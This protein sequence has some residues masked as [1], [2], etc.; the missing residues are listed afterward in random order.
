MSRSSRQKEKYGNN[1]EKYQDKYNEGTA[2]RTRPFSFDDIMLKRVNKRQSEDVK[3]VPEGSRNRSG[4]DIVEGVSNHVKSDRHRHRDSVPADVKK[5][6]EDL[7]KVSSRK[8]EDSSSRREGKLVKGNEKVSRDL[9]SKLKATPDR[10]YSGDKAKGGKAD[11]RAHRKRKNEEWSSDNFDNEHEKR[12]SRD[13]VARER[14]ADRSSGKYDKESK[15]KNQNDDERSRDRNSGKKHDLETAERKGKKES[16]QLP[17]EDSRSKR[18]RSRSREHDKDRARKSISLSPRQHKR[19]SY[20]VHEHGELPS[21]SSKGRSG[22]IH[23]DVERKKISFNGSSSDYRRN[24]D[25]ARRLGGY[26]PRKRRT[27]AA[28][29]TPSPTN[30]SPEKRSATWDLPPIRTESKS[31]GSVPYNF[32]S[33]NQTV[34]STKQDLS[35]MISVTSSTPKP[36]VGV[37]SGASPLKINASVD[38]VQLTQA[39]RPMRRV[40]VENLPASATEEAV[41]ECLNS[42]LLSSGVIHVQATQPCI[43]CIINKEKGQALVEFLTPEDASAALSFDGRS[44]FGSNIKIRRPKDYVEVTCGNSYLEKKVGGLLFAAEFNS[45]N[46]AVCELVRSRRLSGYEKKT[47]AVLALLGLGRVDVQQIIIH[48]SCFRMVMKLTAK[49]R[50]FSGVVANFAVFADFKTG[51]PEKS[52]AATISVSDIVKDS[53]HK[54]FI[55][56]ISKVISSQMLMEIASA[57]GPLKAYHYEFNADL[58]EPY[59]FIEFVD[60]AVTSKA[61]AGLN[62]IRLGGKVLTVVQAIHDGLPVENIG[63]PPFYE[64]PEHA[65]PLL[66]NPTQVLKL[67]NVLDLHSLSSLSEPELEEILEDIRLECARFGTVISVNVVKC[68]TCSTDLE[69]YEVVDTNVSAIGD[70]NLESDDKEER[71]EI[72]SECLDGDSGKVCRSEPSSNADEPEVVHKAAE[73]SSS[74]DGRSEPLSSARQDDEADEAVESSSNCNDKLVDN[75]VKEETCEAAPLD[76]PSIEENLNAIGRDLSLPMKAEVDQLE[77][78]D[79]KVADIL[80]M[81]D[82]P[83][84][85]IPSF[86][87]QLKLEEEIGK[88]S[89]S[90][91]IAKIESD[92]LENCGNKGQSINLEDIF[93]PGCVLVKFK[94]AE[95]SSNAAHCFH[96]RLF[97]NRVVTVEYVAHEHYKARF[98]K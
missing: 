27:E 61:C 97:D 85:D 75:L 56:G 82:L 91:N 52:V 39:T 19:T 25:S 57:F 94:R 8:K 89:D 50:R 44:F 78:D 88:F 22:R 59:A 47:A 43:S 30:R 98:P 77:C 73:G 40:Y 42:F 26:S 72:V 48:C 51:V 16:S 54:I 24:G 6:S 17:Q 68:S 7:E 83:M 31:T 37:L 23:S 81:G 1:E 70:G 55:G 20:D 95:A 66:Q 15:R 92:G 32:Q 28:I 41:M 58:D 87:I 38:S 62:G 36:V 12:H 67:K 9:E 10:N 11:G 90:K 49:L 74:S 71:A 60:Q 5:A 14:H 29:K 2:A 53:P 63:Y 4:K 84:E 35:S 34:S 3:P 65:K 13:L 46:N 96:G 93:D 80:Q 33:A 86:K 45:S 76:D 69:A 21:H 18:R 79:H 64:I